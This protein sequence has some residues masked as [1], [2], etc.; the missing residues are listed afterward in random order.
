MKTSDFYYYLPEELIA[1]HP[2]EKRDESRLLHLKS[3]ESFEDLHFRDIVNFIKPED[4]LVIN[5]TKVLPARIFGSRPGKDEHIEVLLVKELDKDLWQ[6][7]VRP[8]RKMKQDT[9]IEFPHGLYGN[10]LLY[11]SDAAD[12][13]CRV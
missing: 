5:N 12:D 11:T 2:A 6:C 7:M 8:G 4:V 9:I 13:C 10:C 3:D 1:Q